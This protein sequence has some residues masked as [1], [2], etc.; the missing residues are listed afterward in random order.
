M[1]K[2]EDISKENI[3]KVPDGYFDKLP[4]IIQTRVTHP[5]PKNWLTPI[6]VKVA[7]P[8]TAIVLALSVWLAPN[9]ISIEDQLN[10]IQTEQLLVYLDNN[11]LSSD[12]LL[13]G[14]GLNE[15]DVDLLEAEV[16]SDM[17]PM[18]FDGIELTL[19][20]DQF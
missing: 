5:E 8:A 14:D 4:G 16:I 11:D 10:E 1:K 7:L 13:D 18:D 17:E 19:D 2:L 6:L 3:Y 20:T 12:L 9:D 15:D